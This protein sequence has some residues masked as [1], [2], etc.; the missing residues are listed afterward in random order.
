MTGARRVS[1]L[2]G[3][4]VAGLVAVVVAEGVYLWAPGTPVATA[5][6]PVVTG[7][8]ATQA[9]VD[10]ASQATSE[11]FSSTW[12]GYDDHVAAATRQMTPS[13]AARYRATAAKIRTQVLQDH[14]RT[15]T[16]VVR[17]GVVR[18]DSERVQALLFL[19]QVTTSRGH[20]PSYQAYRALVTVVRGDHGWLVDGLSTRSMPS[21]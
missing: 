19:N 3:V 8:I 2:L 11:I 12:Q 14:S 21:Q 4:L 18:S 1:L 13:F 15:L 17:A 10:A 5:A 6:R 16:R 7:P 20:P 9:A